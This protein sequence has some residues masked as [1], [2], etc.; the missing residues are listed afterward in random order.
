MSKMKELFEQH[1]LEEGPES[2]TLEKD[3]R[4]QV[5]R[6][7][8]QITAIQHILEGCKNEK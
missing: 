7:N 8:K 3:M 1:S 5:A 4:A 6:L 2:P